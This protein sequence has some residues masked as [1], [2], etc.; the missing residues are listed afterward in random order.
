MIP[1]SGHSAS[2]RVSP[3]TPRAPKLHEFPNSPTQPA[4]CYLGGRV[5]G[6]K[7]NT[8][9]HAKSVK[10]RFPSAPAGTHFLHLFKLGPVCSIVATR[11]LLQITHSLQQILDLLL[12]AYSYCYVVPVQLLQTNNPN[13]FGFHDQV[14]SLLQWEFV[15]ASRT[16]RSKEVTRPLRGLKES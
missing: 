7:V 14:S 6:F 10:E 5:G 2:M 15:S 1:R 11:G 9:R 16:Q 3:K 12:A 13:C 8:S 4:S